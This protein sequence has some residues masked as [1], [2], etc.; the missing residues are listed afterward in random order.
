MN[1]IIPINDK[2]AIASDRYQ[3]MVC[4]WRP[5]GEDAEKYPAKWVADG[6]YHRHMKDTVASLGNRMLREG[7]AFKEVDM[8]TILR[9]AEDIAET[10]THKAGIEIIA[11]SDSS[12]DSQ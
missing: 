8:S 12:G 1:N 7:N 2:Y 4:V 11:V 9:D 10:L 5:A 6:S 3:W